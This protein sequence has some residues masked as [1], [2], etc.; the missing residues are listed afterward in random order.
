MSNEHLNIEIRT[1]IERVPIERRQLAARALGVNYTN[2][3]TEEQISNSGSLTVYKRTNSASPQATIELPKV[4]L[5]DGKLVPAI[6]IE[7]SCARAYAKEILR[8]CDLEG[9]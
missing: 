7:P 9:L 4:M 3:N 6:H 1:A 2:P 8:I 5:N